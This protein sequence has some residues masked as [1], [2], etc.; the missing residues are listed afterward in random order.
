MSVAL[1]IEHAKRIRSI[2][3]SS[4]PVRL[5]HIV[6]YYLINGT[7]YRSDFLYNFSKIYLILRRT[8]PDTVIDVFT[9]SCKVPDIV[10]GF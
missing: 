6:T 1:A 8:H 7:I 3:L 4:V 10:V 5:Y 9:P 2:V